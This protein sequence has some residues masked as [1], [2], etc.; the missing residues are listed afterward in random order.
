MDVTDTRSPGRPRQF[1]EEVALD[2]ITDVFWEQ[3]FGATT[4]TDLVEA[5][6]VHKPSLYRTFGSKDELFARVL[7][8]YIAARMGAM[9]TRIEAA[10]SGVE[11]LHRF[12]QEIRNDLVDGV[13]SRGCLLIASSCELH[14]TAE[15]FED[16][17]AAYRTAVRDVVR[18]LVVSIGGAEHTIEQ[19]TSVLVTWMFGLDVTVRGGAPTVEIDT[20]IAAMEAIVAQWE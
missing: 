14:G 5:T 9:S 17:G 12:L 2:Q 18:P 6:G 1:D 10:G 3:G 20:V 16:F 11:G 19:R 15:G 13:A 7:R 8:R 4:V